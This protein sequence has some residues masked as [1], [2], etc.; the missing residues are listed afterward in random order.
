MATIF[1]ESDFKITETIEDISGNE[2]DPRNINFIIVY[3]TNKKSKYQVSH[4]NEKFDNCYY[5]AAVGKLI[6]IFAKHGLRPG[7]L[8]HKLIVLSEDDK[9]PLNIRYDKTLTDTNITLSLTG[10]NEF[11]AESSI[12]VPAL[13]ITQA[14]LEK[15]NIKDTDNVLGLDSENGN[16]LIKITLL[17]LKAFFKSFFDTIYSSI[18]HNHNE[19]YQLLGD[20]ITPETELNL[21][22]ENKTVIGSI[23]E[24]NAVAKGKNRA[25]VFSTVLELDAWLENPENVALLKIG[26]NF[27]IL[28]TDVPDY[29][30][31]GEQKQELETQKIDLTT[32]YNKTDIDNFLSSKA[33]ILPLSGASSA[34]RALFTSVPNSNCIYNELTGYYEMNG[35]TDLTEDDMLKIYNVSWNDVIYLRAFNNLLGVD[36]QYNVRTLYPLPPHMSKESSM[37]E[38]DLGNIFNAV[39][40][41][42][43]PNLE[44]LVFNVSDMILWMGIISYNNIPVLTMKSNIS[45]GYFAFRNLKHLYT[46]NVIDWDMYLMPFL[47]EAT[48]LITL[49]LIFTAETKDCFFI[50]NSQYLSFE[51]LDFIVDKFIRQ[52]SFTLTFIVNNSIY[53]KLIDPVNYQTYYDLNQTATAKGITFVPYE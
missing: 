42:Q 11:S 27:Y 45:A 14:A 53:N 12:I 32:F 18:N 33:D 22:T 13:L 16:G 25:R 39:F 50:T 47:M 19:T 9:F 46:F 28:D 26:D 38:I 43:E 4:I 7:T 31:D 36:N 30:W 41:G 29:W 23:N 8:K 17:K 21:E 34:L 44:S 40:D 1:F 48:K 49:K 2:I 20:Y 10:E 5:D 3:Y 35:L 52:Q 37:F 24:V 15:E 6:V 51:S